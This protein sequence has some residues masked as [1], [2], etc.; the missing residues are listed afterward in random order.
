MLIHTSIGNDS[1]CCKKKSHRLNKYWT[2][3]F[4]FRHSKNLTSEEMPPFLILFLVNIDN[5][6]GAS[7]TWIAHDMLFFFFYSFLLVRWLEPT[8]LRLQWRAWGTPWWTKLSRK[9]HLIPNC[10]RSLQ[11]ECHENAQGQKPN[12]QLSLCSI[13]MTHRITKKWGLPH[14][15][16]P[17]RAHSHL[18]SLKQIMKVFKEHPPTSKLPQNWSPQELSQPAVKQQMIY[19]FFI[20]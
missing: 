12:K 8:T 17:S 3:L 6:S 15:S 7:F 10:L 20:F 16:S 5:S 1:K 13:Q 4:L 14:E 11:L 9:G 19:W 18:P 2:N